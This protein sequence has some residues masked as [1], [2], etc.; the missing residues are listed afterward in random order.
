MVELNR[1][2]NIIII[3][4]IWV[5]NHWIPGVAVFNSTANRF[6]FF[7]PLFSSVEIALGRDFFYP[8]LIYFANGIPSAIRPQY[9]HQRTRVKGFR[10]VV[11][12]RSSAVFGGVIAGHKSGD[13][14]IA[15]PKYR[16]RIYK[17]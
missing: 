10:A 8:S 17:I 7:Y 4:A 9:T 14:I 6:F 12:P 13:F 16:R 15:G 2:N 3:Y 5:V 11:F 1:K